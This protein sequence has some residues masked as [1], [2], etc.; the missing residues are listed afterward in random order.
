M[1]E[2][3]LPSDPLWPRAS[4]W[5]RPAADP[6]YPAADEAFSAT[7]TPGVR[8]LGLIG[9]P[10]RETSL[11]P[12]GAHAT[13][14]AIRAALARFS[15]YAGS[16]GID[17]SQRVDV[18]DHGDV[19]EP[20]GRE[21]EERVR[22]RIDA[23]AGQHDL[24]VAIGGDNSI[25]YSVMCGLLGDRLGEAGLVTVDAHH[26]LRDGESN[27]SPVRRLV[28][29]GLPGSHVVQ[30]G[31]A[32]FANSAAYTERARSLGITAIYRDEL[33]RRPLAELMAYALERAGEGGRPVYVDLDVD[34]CDRA[35]VPG[36]PAAAPGG[37]TADELRQLAFLAGADARVIAVD[38]AEIDATADTPDERTVRLG[39]L[40]VLEVAAGLASR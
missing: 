11:S 4:S 5:L 9:V 27:G 6:A 32:D 29:A 37:L 31:I 34:V 17:L 13:P 19:V 1:R 40:L 20:D 8:R 33:R 14:D 38:I 12:T 3:D 7:T 10:A 25:T 24:L 18:R 35:A 28:D 36:C 39:A 21:G 22:E 30:L 16:R 26:D 2:R 15:P 23:I